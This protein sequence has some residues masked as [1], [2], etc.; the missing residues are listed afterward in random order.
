MLKRTPVLINKKFTE[1]FIPTVLT[2]MANSIAMLVDSTIVNITLGAEAFASVNLMTPVIQIY[3]AF[4]ILFGMSCATI[5]AKIK[6]ENGNNTKNCDDLFSTF[7]AVMAVLSIALISLQLIFIDKIVF[8]ITKDATLQVLF[9]SYYIPF[10]IGTPVTLLMT[11]GV[12]I[13]RTEGRPKFASAIILAANILNL[14]FDIIFI[15]FLKLGIAG[16]SIATITGN[17]AGLIMFISHFNRP[18]CSLHFSFKSL[19]SLQ[20]FSHNLKELLSYGASGALGAALITIRVFFL[21]S[22]VQTYGG[23]SALVAFSIVSLCQIVDSAFVAGACQTMVCISSML[24]GEKDTEGIKYSFLKALK[25][26]LVSTLAIT[27]LMEIFAPQIVSVYG[28]SHDLAQSTGIEAVRICA[29]MFPTDALTFLGMYHYISVG[30]NKLATAVSILNGVAFIIPLGLILSKAAGLKGVW[31]SISLAQLLT[32][33]FV[34]FAG[35]KLLRNKKLSLEKSDN[36]ILS[37]SLNS[38]SMPDNMRNELEEKIHAY[39]LETGVSEK[40]I[41]DDS[42][43]ALFNCL[44]EIDLAPYENGA[45]AKD[46]DIRICKDTITVKNIGAEITP[47]HS[48]AV[49]ISKVL[50]INQISITL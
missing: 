37:F 18:D 43:L 28:M 24:F 20:N 4:S 14:I 48:E 17:A 10:I 32:L 39:N 26:L 45:K 40:T 19:H 22:L 38:S 13:I 41:D 35:L 44:D 8:I 42:I 36:D 29:L 6:G 21:N 5:I 49:Q 25:I 23:A 3:L 7:I 31:I 1:F 34:F 9:K 12:Y 27:V 50:G 47:V 2:A 46:S 30:K 11:G 15:V 33:A 16:A